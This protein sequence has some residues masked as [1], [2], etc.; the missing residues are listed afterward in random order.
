[1][2]E[3]FGAIV[4]RRSREGGGARAGANLPAEYHTIAIRGYHPIVEDD[5][6]DRR[7]VGWVKVSRESFWER[8]VKR[9]GQLRGRVKTTV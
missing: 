6:V 3:T 9:G 2:I 8:G 7:N 1:M 4:S 5:G